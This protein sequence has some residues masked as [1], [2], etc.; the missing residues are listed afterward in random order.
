MAPLP[1]TPCAVAFVKAEKSE[2]PGG[3]SRTP[4]RVQKVASIS[5]YG[6]N[7][8]LFAIR[9]LLSHAAFANWLSVIETAIHDWIGLFFCV[10]GDIDFYIGHFF[11]PH[12]VC[13][14][15]CQ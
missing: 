7:L 6:S 10:H 9:P 3:L 11:I 4:K 12:G 5:L 8:R 2:S 14:E 1:A 13:I 15:G